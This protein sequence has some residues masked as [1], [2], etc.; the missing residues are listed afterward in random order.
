MNAARIAKLTEHI[1]QICEETYNTEK[2]MQYH[3]MSQIEQICDEIEKEVE[4][5]GKAD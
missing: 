2:P 5:D 1:R 4:D 3:E